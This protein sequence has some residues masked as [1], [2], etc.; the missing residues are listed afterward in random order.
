[1]GSEKILRSVGHSLAHGQSESNN[2]Q[3]QTVVSTGQTGNYQS[4]GQEY[5]YDDADLNE[6]DLMNQGNAYIQENQMG[7]LL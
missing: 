5:F 3:M 1:M 7:D 4:N 2:Q 6:D